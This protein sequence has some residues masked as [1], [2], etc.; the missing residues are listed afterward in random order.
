MNW[1][2]VVVLSQV[3][4]PA[5]AMISTLPTMRSVSMTHIATEYWCKHTAAAIQDDT[6]RTDNGIVT[7][8]C[9]QVG[10]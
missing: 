2:L 10:P 1:L 5:G 8:Y 4:P 7:A 9:Y 3:T 6:A